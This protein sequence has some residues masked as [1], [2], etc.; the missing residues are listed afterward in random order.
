MDGKK[1]SAAPKSQEDTRVV[2]ALHGRP[3]VNV[4]HENMATKFLNTAFGVSNGGL[5]AWVMAGGGAYYFFYL[6]EQKR[7]QEEITKA[8]N[9]A[10]LMK[11][12]NYVD[13]VKNHE[14]KM[15][16]TK[17]TGA[18][19]GWFGGWFGRGGAPKEE[20]KQ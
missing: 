15:A 18:K 19:K 10:R 2:R 1:N 4:P 9:A 11:E 8:A 3:K 13:F 17:D 14:A 5:A 12:S 16:G 20:T 7:Q 6:P